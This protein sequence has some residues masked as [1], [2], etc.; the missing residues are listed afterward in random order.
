M[1]RDLFIV[2]FSKD[3]ACQLDS[4][5]RSLRD[6]FRGQH[7]GITVLYKAT[8]PA[9]ANGYE[10]LKQFSGNDTISWQQEKS[11]QN[12]AARIL[13][14]LDPDSLVMFLVDD[15]SMFRPCV[16]DEILDAFTDEHLFISLRVSRAYKADTP[17]KFLRTDTFLEW[18]WNFSK[19]R[20]VTWNYPF[21]IDGNIFHAKHIQK[22]ISK[23]IFEAPNSFEGRMHAFRHHWWVKRIKKALTPLE[24]AVF[25]NP[26]N[27]VQVESDT[28]HGDVSAASLNEAFLSGMR[29]NNAALYSA[30]PDATHYSV[31]VSLEKGGAQ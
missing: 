7:S 15:D 24:P 28:W 13:N 3:R 2:I 5:L 18:K 4:L 11:F 17:P 6:N 21:S 22:I 9:Y 1:A 16:L 31:A 30:R 12:D 20:W 27:K 23:I 26:L 8:A 25:N 19:R 29:I 10:K 14:G